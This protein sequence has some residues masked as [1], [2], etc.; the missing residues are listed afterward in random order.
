MSYSLWSHEPQKARPPCPS[1]TPGVF[2][3]KYKTFL[4]PISCHTL[5][6]FSFPGG[7]VV[8]NLPTRAGDLRLI[9]GLGRSPGEEMATHSSTL[10]WE[11]PRTEEPGRLQSTGLQIVGHELATKPPTQNSKIFWGEWE[12]SDTT[13]RLNW[14]ILKCWKHINIYLRNDKYIIWF[15]KIRFQI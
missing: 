5:L 4:L 8:K 10:A 6:Y 9:P 12:E 11:I 3:S 14:I 15:A 2:F 13:E 7:S 1:P